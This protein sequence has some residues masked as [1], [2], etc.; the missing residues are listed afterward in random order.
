MKTNNEKIN[1]EEEHIR[2]LFRTRAWDIAGMLG[3]DE[4]IEADISASDINNMSACY[5]HMDEMLPVELRVQDGRPS[6]R[7]VTDDGTTHLT[8]SHVTILAKI[9]SGFLLPSGNPSW[10]SSEG[11][12][13]WHDVGPSPW[14]EIHGQMDNVVIGF[15][16]DMFLGG[17]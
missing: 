2:D 15:H 14:I 3:A 7:V 5:V 11:T 17:E 8:L 1:Y 12:Q 13:G 4:F 10:L 9:L 16:S 6:F